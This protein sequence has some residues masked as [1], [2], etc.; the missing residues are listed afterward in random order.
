MHVLH[1]NTDSGK[2]SKS[3][4]EFLTVSLLESKGYDPLAY[5][6]FCLGSHYRRSLVFSYENL[7]NAVVSF[8]K[9]IARIASLKVTEGEE[10]D[11]AELAE[12]KSKFVAGL[13]NDLNTSLAITA[14]HNV[15][16]SKANTATKRA[17]LAD[18][19]T[20]LQLDLLANADAYA[21]KE[22]EKAAAAAV[23]V[24]SDDPEIRAIEEAIDA[25][26]AAKKAKNYAEADRIRAELLE[27]GIVLTDTA[28]GTTWAK[29]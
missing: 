26:A 28:Q 3:K 4:G 23:R 7:D 10:I 24:Y 18:F 6:F 15:L 22:A 12:L 27:K 19:D 13:D 17:A 21:K 5:R 16:K 1:L 25:R 11:A 2:M 9:L 29:A 8:N 14:I 20:V